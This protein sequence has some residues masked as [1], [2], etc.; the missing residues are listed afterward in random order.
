MTEIKQKLDGSL[1]SE[2]S[3]SDIQKWYKNADLEQKKL[4][5]SNLENDTRAGVKKI[6]VRIQKDL[7]ADSFERRR[8]AKMWEYENHA[9]NKGSKIVFGID[10]AGRGPLM[11]PVVAA[12][13]CLPKD[14]VILGL[15]DSKKLSVNQREKLYA[16]I[17]QKAIYIGVGISTHQRI[18]EINILNATK[19]AMISAIKNAGEYRLHKVNIVNGEIQNTRYI[20]ETYEE[21]GSINME[22]LN[23]K[24]FLLIDAVKLTDIDIEQLSIIKGDQKSVSIAA[25]SIIAKV[26]RDRWVDAQSVKYPEYE[27]EKNKGYGTEVH[28][29]ALKKF[30]ACDLHRKSFIKNLL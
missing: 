9:Y 4:A 27:F 22:S 18:D 23:N 17:Y 29:N 14:S 25:A 26:T 6:A 19:E 16:E 5:F 15:N 13:V 12:A 11:G 20:R 3:I 1:I 21:T 8:L 2:L 28:R 24:M 10:E 30:G 7:D